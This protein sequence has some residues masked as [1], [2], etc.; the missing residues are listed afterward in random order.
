MQ[1]VVRD[2]LREVGRSPEILW[3]REEGIGLSGQVVG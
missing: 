1:S 3:R 2:E